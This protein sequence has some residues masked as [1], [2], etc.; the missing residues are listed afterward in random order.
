MRASMES[1]LSW[2][3][4]TGSLYLSLPFKNV[5]VT[6]PMREGNLGYCLQMQRY[7]FLPGDSERAIYDK[8]GMQAGQDARSSTDVSNSLRVYSGNK[9]L[10]TNSSSFE[11]ILATGF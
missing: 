9:V 6:R 10:I 4:H 5:T 2:K 7:R 11:N 1:T 8:D 3:A